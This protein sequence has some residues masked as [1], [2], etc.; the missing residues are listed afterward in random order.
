VTISLGVAQW[1]PT[2]RTVDEFVQA[3]DPVLDEDGELVHRIGGDE[4]VGIGHGF[5]RRLCEIVRPG[6]RGQ[7]AR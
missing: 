7:L 5:G 4:N 1:N 2:I 3:A 6:G